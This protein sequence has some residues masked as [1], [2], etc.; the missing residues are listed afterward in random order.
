MFK[1]PTREW[2]ALRT[3]D[4]PEHN[5][6]N[7]LSRGITDWL[8]DYRDLGHDAEVLLRVERVGRERGYQLVADL[9]WGGKAV[10][11]QVVVALKPCQTDEERDIIEHLADLCDN[12]VDRSEDEPGFPGCPRCKAAREDID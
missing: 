3:L 6:L 1:Y 4:G 8:D 10:N 2:L 7:K 5:T 12:S 11:G 9:F